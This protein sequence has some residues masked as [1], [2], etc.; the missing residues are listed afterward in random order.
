MDTI[1]RV[2]LI[3]SDLS[4]IEPERIGDHQP[5]DHTEPDGLDL[6]S[7]DRLEL[8]VTVEEEFN[9]DIPDE[10]VDRMVA[11]VAGVA[12]YLDRRMAH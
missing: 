7:L 2:R 8:I 11:T 4:G 1:Q 5:L 9:I 3:A 10:D 12:A 6:D